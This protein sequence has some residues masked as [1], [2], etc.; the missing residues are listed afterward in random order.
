MNL[1]AWILKKQEEEKKDIEKTEQEVSFEKKKTID[2]KKSR[3]KSEKHEDSEKQ[4][5]ELK[6][7]LDDWNLDSAT[8]NLVEK[9]VNSDVIW[10]EEIKE[11]FEKIEE[12][13]NNENISKYLPG[14]SIIKKEEYKKSLTDDIVRVQTL[15]KLN[16]AL[17]ILANHI[18]PDSSMW[19]NL[20]WGFMAMLDK[21]LVKIQENH[22]DIKNSLE[23]VEEYK[24]PKKQKTFWEEIV[25]FIKNIFK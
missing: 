6:N 3:E 16:T 18:N 15:T 7:L 12:I 4:L 13:E 20:F 11:I 22:I 14:D 8:H 1:E 10:E 21:N 23:K 2:L 24:N 9:V 19:L 5:F 17:T 25:N